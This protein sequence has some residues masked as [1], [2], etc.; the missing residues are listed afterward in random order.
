MKIIN[1]TP[2][3]KDHG[4]SRQLSGSDIY[5]I[6]LGSLMLIF[7]IIGFG[8]LLLRN[9]NKNEVKTGEIEG[10]CNKNEVKMRE[11]EGNCNKNEVKTGEIEGNIEQ[12]PV[13]MKDAVR[14]GTIKLNNENS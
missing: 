5:V 4:K 9:C 2:A 7:C 3:T 10:N 1:G 12:E 14:L 8:T 11:I 6:V 13:E